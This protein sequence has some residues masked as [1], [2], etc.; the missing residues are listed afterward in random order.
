MKHTPY[1]EF[2]LSVTQQ[3]TS[4]GPQK[5]SALIALYKFWSHVL[6]RQFK[7]SMYQEFRTMAFADAE[8]GI[9][10]GVEELV[11][12]YDRAIREKDVVGWDLVRDF[13]EL[14]RGEGRK[15]EGRA[16]ER[17]RVLVSGRESRKEV[18]WALEQCLDRE[19]VA[20]LGDGVVPSVG[21]VAAV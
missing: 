6:V 16:L 13:V 2:L 9:R 18:K 3:R 5:T 4:T 14:V 12:F 1:P 17:L 7:A 11:K 10:V 21:G 15:G 8:A 19:L 20:M